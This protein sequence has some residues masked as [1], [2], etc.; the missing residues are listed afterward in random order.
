MLNDT[1]SDEPPSLH[2]LIPFFFFELSSHATYSSHA[3][4]RIPRTR[5]SPSP[6][7]SHPSHPPSSKQRVLQR[8][9]RLSAPCPCATSRPLGGGVPLNDASSIRSPPVPALLFAEARAQQ[10]QSPPPARPSILGTPGRRNTLAT[11]AASTV[12]A[13]TPMSGSGGGYAY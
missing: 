4:L 7:L 10:G 2:R 1:P 12:P 13:P 6:S 3:K 9:T 8:I 11:A 5:P